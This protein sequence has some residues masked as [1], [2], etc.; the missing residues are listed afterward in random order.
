[1]YLETHLLLT[2]QVMAINITINN[3]WYMMSEF[4]RESHSEERGI[5]IRKLGDLS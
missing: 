5:T 4:V 1:M 2:G 3:E